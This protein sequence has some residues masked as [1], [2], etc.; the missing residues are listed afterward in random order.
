MPLTKGEKIEFGLIMSGITG[1][2]FS[3]LPNMEIPEY[4][5]LG[6]TKI[7]RKST[8]GIIVDVTK[9]CL[10]GMIAFSALYYAGKGI[11]WLLERV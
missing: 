2:S 6:I 8:A 10:E 7:H 1:A 4:I 9:G 3:M 11:K 5:D